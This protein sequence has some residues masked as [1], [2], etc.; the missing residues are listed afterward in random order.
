MQQQILQQ[1]K[2]VNARL[3]A[4]ED[5]VTSTSGSRQKPHGLSKL[6]SGSHK[7]KS[8]SSSVKLH[9][10]SSES[11]SDS[12]TNLPKLS[13]LRSSV[14]L[15][16]QVD[17]RLRDL[18]S[19]QDEAGM[20]K[21]KKIKSQRGGPVDVLVKHKI[22]WPHEAILGGVNRSRLTYDQLSMSQ[23]VQGFCKNTLD[24]TCEQ[25]RESMITYMADL[26]EDA[27][28]FSWQ[29]AK[30]AHAVLCCELERGTVTWDDTVRIDRIRRAHAQKHVSSA[31]NWT[32]GNASNKPWYCKFFQIGSCHY[33]KDHEVGGRLH[34]HICASCLQQGKI[35]THAEKD[36]TAVKKSS[37]KNLSQAVH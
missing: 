13:A 33:S 27:T 23:W 22:A 21:S 16:R 19:S 11:D 2:R 35:M 12:G 20:P 5:Q 7:L 17:A 28:D 34:R 4:V 8:K 1:L 37:S 30:A 26:M 15:Q 25:K 14:S 3:D 31:K 6:S 29:G 32:E 24:E 9:S 10:T 18:E 36:C